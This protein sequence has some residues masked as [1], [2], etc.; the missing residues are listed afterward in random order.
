MINL[1]STQLRKAAD[2]KDQIASLQ[3]QLTTLLGGSKTSAPA[4]TVKPML[5]KKGAMSAAGKAR[6]IA[7]QKARWAKIKAAKAKSAPVAKAVVARKPVAKAGKP[8]VAKKGRVISAEARAK[9]AAAAKLMWVKIKAA[10]AA[11]ASKK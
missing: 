1:T 8:A 3:A 7:A 4:A 2:L 5:A 10:Q 9:M 6:I 11:K